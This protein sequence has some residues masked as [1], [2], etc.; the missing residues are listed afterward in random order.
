MGVLL[1][2]CNVA[3][4][5]MLCDCNVALG[6]VLCEPI[7]GLRGGNSRGALVGLRILW[8]PVSSCLEPPWLLI[9]CNR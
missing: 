5:D 4:G 9:M 3:L 7:G 8:L 2:G 1:C 6:G